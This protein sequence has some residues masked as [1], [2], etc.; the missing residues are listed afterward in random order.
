MYPPVSS[1]VTD[2][3]GHTCVITGSCASRERKWAVRTLYLRGQSQWYAP[4]LKYLVL[5]PVLIETDMKDARARAQADHI[6][7]QPLQILRQHSPFIT[8]D[9][10]H[11][12]LEYL[13][14]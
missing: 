13:C 2:R 11:Y 10:E 1:L 5:F 8:A 7:V 6:D 3:N 12:S 4:V 14:K 9:T